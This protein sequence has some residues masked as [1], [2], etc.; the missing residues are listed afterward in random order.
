MKK[1]QYLIDDN[2]IRIWNDNLLDEKEIKLLME[3]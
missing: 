2:I 1:I 3:K